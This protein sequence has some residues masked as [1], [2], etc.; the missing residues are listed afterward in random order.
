MRRR[1]T[2]VETLQ[3]DFLPCTVRP[4]S[5]SRRY[6]R[7]YDSSLLFPFFRCLTDEE[8]YRDYLAA[9]TWLEYRKKVVRNVMDSKAGR[10]IAHVSA[11]AKGSTGWT[12]WPGTQ[13]KM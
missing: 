12:A 10:F 6:S 11:T 9:E 2:A 13:H 8:V 7:L 3:T 1:L 5:S 4:V